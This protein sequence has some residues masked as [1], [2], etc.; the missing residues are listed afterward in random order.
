MGVTLGLRIPDIDH[1][2][3]FTKHRSIFTHG[4][5][6]PACLFYLTLFGQQ[7]LHYVL[8]NNIAQMLVSFDIIFYFTLGFCI[9]YAIHLAFDMSPKKWSGIAL[10]HTPLGR[11]PAPLSWLWME[12]GVLASIYVLIALLPAGMPSMQIGIGVALLI[13]AR[14]QIKEANIVIPFLTLAISSY[15][16][17]LLG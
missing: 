14:Y 8:S 9:S 6:F 2:L 3:P 12:L 15:G 13:F 10:I 4:L 11:L 17:I 7:T 5:L 16:I 1:N